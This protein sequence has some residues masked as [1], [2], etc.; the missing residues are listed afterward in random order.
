MPDLVGY[1]QYRNEDVFGAAFLKRVADKNPDRVVRAVALSQLA[2]RAK[3]NGDVEASLE[4]NDELTTEYADV[5]EISGALL[6]LSMGRNV[7]PGTAV[8]DFDVTTLD[9]EEVTNASLRGTYYLLQFWATWCGPC[10]GEMKYLHDTY[11]KHKDD[12]FTIVS[13][14]LDRKV[15]DVKSY[16]KEKWPMPWRNVFVDGEVKD[17]LTKRFEVFAVPRLFLVD[18]NGMIVEAGAPLRGEKLESTIA[19]R[20]GS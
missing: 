20:L 13:V 9:G 17:D 4:Y 2:L 14:S 12:N 15:D 10:R 18:P 1:M 7:K 8:P 6:M 3:E 5:K 19:A 11:K 16:R